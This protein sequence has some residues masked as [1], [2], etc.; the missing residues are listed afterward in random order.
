MYAYLDFMH[1]IDFTDEVHYSP[2]LM[3]IFQLSIMAYILFKNFVR[4]LG[5]AQIHDEVLLGA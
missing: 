5:S 3:L 4:R 2:T 1:K